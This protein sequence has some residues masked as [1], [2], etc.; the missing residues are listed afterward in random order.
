M[1]YTYLIGRSRTATD[2]QGTRMHAVEVVAGQDYP[3]WFGPALCGA[4]PAR[5]SNGW[6]DYRAP[7]ATCPKCLA[8]LAKL[9]VQEESA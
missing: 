6:S 4:K 7:A 2:S 9:Q 8:K 3:A 1:I 5:R